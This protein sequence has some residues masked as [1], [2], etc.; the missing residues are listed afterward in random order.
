MQGTF[1]DPSERH[2]LR[3]RQA[4]AFIRPDPRP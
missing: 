2:L 3:A 1:L 4:N